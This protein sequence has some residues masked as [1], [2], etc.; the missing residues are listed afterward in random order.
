MRKLV[1]IAILACSTP[2]YADDVT[3]QRPP[4]AVA[5]FVDAVPIPQAN[6]G[7]DRATL[8]LI[9]PITFPS[10][11]EVAEPELRL[12][13]LRINPKNHAMSRRGFAQRL[14]LLD[15]RT[16]GA[17]PRTIR[18]VSAGARIGD[19]QWSPDGKTIAFTVTEADAIRLWLAD[20]ATAAARMI[21]TPPLS[22]VDGMPCDWLPDSHALVCRIVP[23]D[24]KPPPAA[25][26]ACSRRC[27]GSAATSATCRC[28]PR[29]TATARASPRSTCCGS[30]SAGS[31]PTSRAPG[32]GPRRASPPHTDAARPPPAHAVAGCGRVV[33]NA[34][35]ED[36]G[37]R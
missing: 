6:L 27:R 26:T 36:P 18:G 33:R 12:A 5:A 10:I 11:A 17:V 24:V 21:A 22:G 35:G 19:V 28:P 16:K 9:T 30:R 32:R 23:R 4:K 37:R 13:G 7:P 3:Y 2:L 31:T 1:A 29:P 20:V 15:T 34:H 8:L 25:P 14:E